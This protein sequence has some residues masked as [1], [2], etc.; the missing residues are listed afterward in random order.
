[1]KRSPKIV[2]GLVIF[3]VALAVLIPLI[4]N[5]KKIR[6]ALEKQLSIALGRTVRIGDLSFPPF[7]AGLVASDVSIADDPS[8]SSTPILTAKG[9]RIAVYLAPLIFRRE[10]KLRGFQIE[11]PQINLIRASDGTWNFSRIGHAAAVAE[12]ANSKLSLSS[13]PD[14]SVSRILI[15]DGRV[16]V[17]TLPAH[18][19]PTVYEHV[20]LSAHHFSFTSHFSFEL[21]ANLPAGG[22]LGATGRLGPINRSDAATSP[23]DTHLSVKNFDPVAAGFLDP[24]AGI[25]LLADF[26]VHAASDGQALSTN[27]TVHLQNL[28]LR[29]GATPAPKPVDLAFTGTHRLKE[30]TGEIQD[31]SLKIGD[32]AIHV[33]G[34]YQIAQMVV[35]DADLNLKITGQTLPI[36]DLQ[37]LMAAAG[38]RL[39][40]GSV[41]RGGTLSLNLAVTGEEKSLLILGTIAAEKTRLVGFD[42]GSKVHGI[43]ALSGVET[44]N[45]TDFEKLQMFIRDTNSGVTVDKIDAVI[46]AMGKLIGGGTISP[47]DQLDFR[48]IV[49]GVK[50]KGI[51]KVGVGIMSVFSGSSG[52]TSVPMRITGTDEAP[53]ITAD[54]GGLFRKQT[55]SL[56][57]NRN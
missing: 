6:P 33:I 38:V 50:A 27:G 3:V 55:K 5:A 29:K 15:N 23:C 16:V 1:M 24:N 52:P 4:V 30:N 12:T 8:F 19:E 36:D 9:V 42:V 46:P 11:S 40:N 17:A 26:D 48:L 10:V 34:T 57:N 51:G 32:A 43:A 39:P 53:S 21:D 14:L 20:N 7:S 22:T 44:G 37:M 54:V 47:D 45:T 2:V 31:A 28:K 49:I 35:K 41:L 25:V 56:F 13:L 18:G